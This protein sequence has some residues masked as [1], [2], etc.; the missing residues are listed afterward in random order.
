MMNAALNRRSLGHSVQMVA[1]MND[2]VGAFISGLFDEPNTSVAVIVGTGTN[3]CY[4]EQDSA[5]TKLPVDNARPETMLLNTEWGALADVDKHVFP[6][7]RFDIAVD[8]GSTNHGQQ[9]FEK[10]IAGTALGELVRLALG[11]LQEAGVFTSRCDALA[12]RHGIEA[13]LV[14]AF[15][16]DITE[17][18]SR[19]QE[20]CE[21]LHWVTTVQDR[22]IIHRTAAAVIRRAG[23][24]VAAG[25]WG[26]ATHLR[27]TDDCCVIMDGSVWAH[28]TAFRSALTDAL[29]E[30]APR[31]HGVRLVTAEDASGKGAAL[32]AALYAS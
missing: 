26:I 2:T 31:P 11:E 24:L 22:R 18:H 14:A 12:E 7:N 10:M 32:L 8:E 28:G 6:L 16:E 20:F 30:L 27:R 19:I 4:V 1:V 5:I 29:Q 3:M 25:I 17:C 9:L 13:P 23:R 15:A 21:K